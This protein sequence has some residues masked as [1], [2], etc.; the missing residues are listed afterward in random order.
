MLTRQHLVHL[1]EVQTNPEPVNDPDYREL[2]HNL[3]A[4]E[5]QD[6]DGTLWWGIHPLAVALLT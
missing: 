2:L 4:L 1:R 5:Y 6:R 3:S